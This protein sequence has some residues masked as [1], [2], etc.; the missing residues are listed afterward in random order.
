MI[1]QSVSIRT[2]FAQCLLPLALLMSSFQAQAL[3]LEL[4]PSTQGVTLGDQVTFELFARSVGSDQIGS[5][6]V[7][8]GFDSALL[9]LNEVFFGPSL[10]DPD[11]L[12]SIVG[13]T[14]GIDQVGLSQVSLL[15]DLSGLQDGSDLLLSSIVFDTLSVGLGSLGFLSASVSDG[16]GSPLQQ[17]LLG[18]SVSV[19]VDPARIPEP[20]TLLLLTAGLLML[21]LSKVHLASES[22]HTA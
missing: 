15:F 8:L 17:L 11:L 6:D 3:L 20:G 14:P 10:G 22:M 13:V 16:F 19:M 12:E 7:T 9:A 1:S 21:R 18:E 5:F 4:S 2:R